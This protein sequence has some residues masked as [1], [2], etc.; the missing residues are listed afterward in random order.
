MLLSGYHG[1]FS[2]GLCGLRQTRTQVFW[3]CRACWGWTWEPKAA[4]HHCGCTRHRRSR[5]QRGG[6]N[7]DSPNSGHDEYGF[8]RVPAGRRGRRQAMQAANKLADASS[9]SVN[10]GTDAFELD[11]GART[12][13]SAAD[14]VRLLAAIPAASRKLVDQFDQ[15]LAAAKARANEEAQAKRNDKPLRRRVLDAD[16]LVSKAA[17]AKQRAVDDIAKLKQD[18]ADINLRVEEQE[19]SLRQATAKHTEAVASA[20]ALKH[21][22]AREGGAALLPP[23][24]LVMVQGLQTQLA[25]LPGAFFANN[26]H[27]ALSA[28]GSQVPALLALVGTP[29]PS[30]D[31]GGDDAMPAEAAAETPA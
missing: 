14:E 18:I 10:S 12:P 31:P 2:R 27:A 28:I 3:V 17:Q 16:R 22:Y 24:A 15:R 6:R 19:A 1:S 29:P 8:V 7:N 4:C 13:N 21:E 20:A 23:H 9:G 26:H 11:T 25:S 30:S 5:A